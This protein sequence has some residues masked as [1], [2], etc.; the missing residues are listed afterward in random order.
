[1]PALFRLIQERGAIS[2]DEM[3]SVFNMG[4][5]MVLVCPQDRVA[6]VRSL[7]PEAWLIGGVATSHG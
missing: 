1:M 3:A 6:Q 2:D 4:V 7:L 5:G